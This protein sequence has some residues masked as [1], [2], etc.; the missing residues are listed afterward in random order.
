MKDNPYGNYDENDVSIL[1]RE[2]DNVM[3]SM[4]PRNI[5]LK[6]VFGGYGGVS[7]ATAN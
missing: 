2:I 7:T 4:T 3:R 5:G 1:E 6:P